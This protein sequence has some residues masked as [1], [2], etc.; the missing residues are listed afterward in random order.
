M[1]VDLRGSFHNVLD[2]LSEQSDWKLFRPD[3][4]VQIL[5]SLGNTPVG[6]RQ[7]KRSLPIE[8]QMCETSV[9]ALRIPTLD[10]MICIKAFLC[11]QRNQTRDYL[12][13]AALSSLVLESSVMDSLMKIPLRYA[14]FGADVGLLVAQRLTQ[15]EPADRS[16]ISLEGY[17]GLKADWQNWDRVRQIC[18]RFGHLLGEALIVR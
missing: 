3:P 10:E 7:L 12:D 6:F 2:L 17:K 15:C 14:E 18:V 5:G 9:G 1:L 4:P 16:S 13:F 11:C 8:T